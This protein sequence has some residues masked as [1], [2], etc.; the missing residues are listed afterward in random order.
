MHGHMNVRFL[1][2]CAPCAVKMEV[3]IFSEILASVNKIE[4]H[5]MSDDSRFR[6]DY[7]EYI[8][9]TTNI[10]SSVEKRFGHTL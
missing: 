8:N 7:R 2:L 4:C 1:E 6:T 9:H 10:I 3:A 5:Q